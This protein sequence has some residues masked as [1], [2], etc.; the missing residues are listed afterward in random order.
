MAALYMTATHT[1]Y[2]TRLL[3]TAALAWLTLCTAATAQK[4]VRV[5]SETAFDPEE[6]S[7]AINP[8]NP[9]NMIVGANID[10]VYNTTDG[11]KTWTEKRASSVF[12]VWG[13]PM[14]L[15]DPQGNAYYAHLSNPTNGHWIDRIVVQKSTDGGGTWSEGAGMGVNGTKNQDKH[16]LAYDNSAGSPRRGYL[17]CSWTE[18]DKYGSK[19]A[20]DSS[21]IL[22]S[23]STDGGANW[24][25][26]VTVSDTGGDCI[27]SD[28]TAEGAVPAVGPDGTVYVSWSNRNKLWC[29]KSTDGGKTWGRDVMVTD[30]VGGWDQVV[31]GLQ[32]SNGLPVTL[33]DAGFS[34]NYSGTVYLVWGDTRN[35][36]Q[37]TDVFLIKSTDGG[38]TWSQT[39]RVNND[40]GTRHQFMP[41]AAID[42]TNGDVWVLYYDRR[43]TTGAATDVYAAV[44]SDGGETFRSYRMR[45]STFTPTNGTFFGD[46][47]GI[48]AYGGSACATW[49]RMDN[50]HN[51][52]WM[53]HV[54]DTAR[55]VSAVPGALPPPPTPGTIAVRPNPSEAGFTIVCAAA[56]QGRTRVEI[57]DVRGTS[58]RT[59]YD[60]PAGTDTPITLKWDGTNK[61]GVM[62]PRGAYFCRMTSQD[63]GV[64]TVQLQLNRR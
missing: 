22:F 53:A 52:V 27:D 34:Q 46:Y 43:A 59:L 18:F 35:G 33:C 28:S 48:A 39:K 55:N 19:A 49:M 23:Y 20:A 29:D 61:R 58:L 47:I 45:D 30:Q 57:C 37:N 7:I 56:T 63:G 3:C 51:S 31:S 15:F 40:A 42:P 5:S 10:Y 11:G 2:R 41:A 9:L 36:T 25:G 44:S 8:L 60:G 62:V 17:Y 21:R 16:W 6:V 1:P 54:T 13:D 12:G 4:P 32:R 64:A 38:S 14:M 50:G 24:A 26:P